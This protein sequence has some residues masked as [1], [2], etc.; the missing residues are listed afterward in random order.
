MNSM[1]SVNTPD[2][3]QHRAGAQ[4][5]FEGRYEPSPVPRVRD[6]V[7]LYEA[8]GGA[9]GNTLEDRPVV[10]L[11]TLGMQSRK[12]RKNPIMRIEDNGIYVAVASV[13]GAPKNPAWYGNLIA[14][15]DVLVQDG[16]VVLHLRA[17]EVS[18]TDKQRW[19]VV[20]ERFW[21]YY[22]Q[23]RERAAAASREIPLVLLEPIT[24]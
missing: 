19:W 13:G 22:P 3:R 1:Q 6:Q 24:R 21:P 20:A 11:T 2:D 5:L 18:G 23:Y 15:P 9:E 8:T 10:I 7:A 14:H 4:D 12:V 16:A 17:R